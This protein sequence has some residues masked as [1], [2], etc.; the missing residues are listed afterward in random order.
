MSDVE[1]DAEFVN[2][3]APDVLGALEKDHFFE[4]LDELFCPPVDT[5]KQ[6]VRCGHSFDHSVA[7]LNAL[8]MDAD[9]VDDVLAV[10]KSKGGC[11][12]CEVLYNVAEESRL[13]ARCWKAR[14]AELA[15]G[16]QP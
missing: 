3:I 8:G 11:C 13:K 14:A 10:L 6:S 2:D 16:K 12:D 4:R 1:S 15:T 7:I 9:D 5:S